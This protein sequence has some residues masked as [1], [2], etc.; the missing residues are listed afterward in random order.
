[1]KAYFRL[2]IIFETAYIPLLVTYIVLIASTSNCMCDM[3]IWFWH[4]II[5][6]IK[7]ETKD[8]LFLLTHRYNAMILEC[9]ADGESIEIITRAHGNVQ[10]FAFIGNRLFY[11]PTKQWNCIS[12]WNYSCKIKVLQFYAVTMYVCICVCALAKAYI[13]WASRLKL[14]LLNKSVKYRVFFFYLQKLILNKI[15]PN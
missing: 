11:F 12:I 13:I 5:F 9:Q 7:G 1:M 3:S 8:L 2:T 6:C 14:G 10:V 4:Q 15:F